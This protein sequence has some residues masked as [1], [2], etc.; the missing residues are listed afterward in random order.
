MKFITRV[1]MACLFLAIAACE[2]DT[3]SGSN[4]TV[5]SSV[6]ATTESRDDSLPEPSSNSQKTASATPNP[7]TPSDEARTYRAGTDYIELT[8]PVPTVDRNHIE[9]TEVFWYGCSHCFV[10]EPIVHKWYTNL[11]ADVNFQRSPAMWDKGGVMERHARMFYTAKALGVLDRMHQKIFDA[12]NLKKVKFQSEA[13]IADFFVE[14]GVDRDVFNKTFNSF[15][16]TSAVKQ[17]EARQRSYQIQGTPELIVNGKYRVTGRLAGN[18]ED[19][20]KI[21]EY[22]IKKE[23]GNNQGS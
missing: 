17:A 14:N 19:M 22:L 12:M 10:F 6:A 1:L 21:A 20:L 7:A 4:S 5:E 23:R 13:E 9:V 8:P 16:V 15:G 3:G 11:P 2:A 18:H